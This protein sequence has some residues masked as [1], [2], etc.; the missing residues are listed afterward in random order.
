MPAYSLSP[1]ESHGFLPQYYDQPNLYYSHMNHMMATPSAH[2][3]AHGRMAIPLHGMPPDIV[4]IKPQ[5]TPSPLM[6][7][8]FGPSPFLPEEESNSLYGHVD[9]LPPVNETSPIMMHS[10]FISPTEHLEPGRYD[11]HRTNSLPTPA[12]HPLVVQRHYLPGRPAMIQRHTMQVASRPAALHRQASLQ[13]PARS[14]SPHS[15]GDVFG[16]AP[17]SP[18]KRPASSLGLMAH[19]T[20]PIDHTQEA[21]YHFSQDMGVSSVVLMR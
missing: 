7:E 15:M 19:Q 11:F 13:P 20:G 16:L 5:A 10:Q 3:I 4:N 17:G 12:V 18:V 9:E 1:S 8:E 2:Q 14:A 21:M 6:E